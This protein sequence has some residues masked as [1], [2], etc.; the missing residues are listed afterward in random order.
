M[1]PLTGGLK[2]LSTT[3]FN[4]IVALVFFLI[5]GHFATP[6]FVGKVAIIQLMETIAGS[7]FSILPYGL[8]TREVSHYYASSKDY[9]RIAYTSLSYSLL[10]S[11]IFLFLFFFP[12][13]LWLSIPYFILYIFMNYQGQLLSGLGKFTEVN[14]GSAIFT[15]SRWG[16]SIIAIFY[17]SIELLI[18]IW[19]LGA[20]L[21]ALYYQRYLPFKFF[22]DKAIFKEIVKVGFPIYLSGIVSFISSQG[23]RVV[24]AFLLGSY[25]LGIYQLVALAAVVPS[26]L[27]YS[28]SSSLLPSST[29]Y[30]VKGKDIAQMSSITFRIVTLV[31]LP[32][33]ILGYAVSPIFIS[34]LFPQYVSGITV[35]QL[36]ILF[37]TATMPLQFLSTFMISA[38]K[39]Y[40]PFIIIS[41]VSAVEVI[42]VSYYLIP[43]IGI[44]G[45]AIAQVINVILT[46]ALFLIFSVSQGVFRLERK[47]I[48][49]IILIGLS[50]LALINWIVGLVVVLVGFKLLGIVSS[51]E[52]KIV[53]NFA[54]SILKKVT[55]ILYLVAR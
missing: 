38:K 13:Y 27:I 39:S 9:N 20:L 7:F 40:R 31:S 12:S 28:F 15:L 4:S 49:C 36:L 55:K 52:I 44:L 51:D 18:L 5:A 42:G 30:Y 23:D 41:Y 21:K 35:M 2:F 17:H 26:M 24:T 48:A 43:R 45:A 6:S 54:P 53:E 11:P 32:V 50:F 25:Y 29:Y 34:K 22:I 1:N 16:L 14:V 8:V 33:A 47:E 3:L 19:T 46:S 10:V 37:L